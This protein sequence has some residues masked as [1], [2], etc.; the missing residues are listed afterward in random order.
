MCPCDGSSHRE[1]KAKNLSFL[2]LFIEIQTKRSQLMGHTRLY[3]WELPSAIP[4]SSEGRVKALWPS[5]E[6]LSVKFFW[7]QK[8]LASLSWNNF[9]F[10]LITD[11]KR[12]PTTTHNWYLPRLPQ[13]GGPTCVL[14]YFL[15]LLWVTSKLLPDFFLPMTPNPFSINVEIYSWI[16]NYSNIIETESDGLLSLLKYFLSYFQPLSLQL[17][18]LVFITWVKIN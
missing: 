8:V 4:G 13:W 16:I 9:L 2:P 14:Q 7:R 3:H 18:S 5:S 6:N 1:A 10:Y 15:L 17:W 11:R 12:D